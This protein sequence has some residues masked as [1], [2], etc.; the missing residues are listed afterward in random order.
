MGMWVHVV[1]PLPATAISVCLVMPASVRALAVCAHLSWR[2]WKQLP[3]LGHT[4][5]QQLYEMGCVFPL[6]EQGRHVSEA[7]GGQIV[8]LKLSGY[9]KGLDLN[10]HLS[11]S[12]VHSVPACTLL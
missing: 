7:W 1:C 5:C 12:I 2:N 9:T 3:V 4:W 11:R 10:S 8:C 6:T